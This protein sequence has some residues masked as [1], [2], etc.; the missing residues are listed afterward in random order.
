MD[1]DFGRFVCLVLTFLA[2]S[3]VFVDGDFH[4]SVMSSACTKVLV[5]PLML[6]TYALLYHVKLNNSIS[7]TAYFA[8]LSTVYSGEC[9]PECPSPH[10]C[11][12]VGL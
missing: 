2:T 7:C 6:N 3:Q 5:S 10:Q 4:K 12:N 8:S 11:P 9:R 1:F